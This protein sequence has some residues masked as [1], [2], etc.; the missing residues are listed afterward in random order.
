MFSWYKS[1][2]AASS[3]ALA[4]F[5]RDS[6]CV[7]EFVDG[8]ARYFDPFTYQLRVLHCVAMSIGLP[9][10]VSFSSARTMKR[11]QWRSQRVVSGLFASDHARDQTA[12]RLAIAG[13]RR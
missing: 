7:Q 3:C 11:S 12:F 9:D 8:I 5:R 6:V 13:T 4:D 10:A 1:I 2:V